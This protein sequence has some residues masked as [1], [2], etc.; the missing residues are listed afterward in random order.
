[1]TENLKTLKDIAYKGTNPQSPDEL[2]YS[3]ELLKQE[4]IK[5]VKGDFKPE[6]F[7]GRYGF[8][9]DNSIEEWIKLFFNI[10]EDELK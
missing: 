2:H 8:N 4:A 1:M 7:H 6:G 5:W 10:S 3:V 9:W